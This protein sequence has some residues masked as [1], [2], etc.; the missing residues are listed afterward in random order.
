MM[1][2]FG[3]HT[4]CSCGFVTRLWPARGRDYIVMFEKPQEQMMLMISEPESES[5]L[6][7]GLESESKLE[8]PR[9]HQKGTDWN[10]I[11]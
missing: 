2:I 4:V 7:S 5:G 11:E 3:N 10:R 6:D 8:R 1:I 9:G